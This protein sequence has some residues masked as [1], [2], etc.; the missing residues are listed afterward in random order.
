MEINIGMKRV[1]IEKLY[2]E[3]GKAL[4]AEGD[5][6]V[7]VYG[8]VEPEGAV[9]KINNDDMERPEVHDDIIYAE[10]ND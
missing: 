2:E 7:T 6:D 5:I 8:D 4:S 9:L 3:I 10:V 1:A